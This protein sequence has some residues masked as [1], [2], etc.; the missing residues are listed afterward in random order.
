MT[1]SFWASRLGRDFRLGGKREKRVLDLITQ[2]L[3]MVQ[4]CAREL[5]QMISSLEQMNWV[6]KRPSGDRLKI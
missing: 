1:R 4:R 3:A 5:K 2:H 6:L